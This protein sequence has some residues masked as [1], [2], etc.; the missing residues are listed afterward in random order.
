MNRPRF[1]I[2]GHQR[3]VSLVVALI[4]LLIMTLLGL[5]ALR[6]T[7]LQEH[8]S[9]NM[10]DRNAQF[11]A[12]ESALRQAE[13]QISAG[14]TIPDSGCTSGICATPVAGAADRWLDSSFSGWQTSNGTG[15]RDAAISTVYIAEYMGDGAYGPNCNTS[16]S[17][18]SS[19]D[20]NCSM[21][22]YRVTARSEGDGRA[23][24]V[25]QTNFVTPQ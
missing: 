3:G 1:P 15:N 13:A 19:V 10:I 9:A 25:L 16:K 6:T 5:A 20:P 22:R 24:V 11:Q 14:V 17:T 18:S 21:L 8:M 7:G 2:A 12:A 23:Q 4:L